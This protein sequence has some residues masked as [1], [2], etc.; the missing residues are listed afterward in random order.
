VPLVD[1]PAILRKAY[2]FRYDHAIFGKE[3]FRDHVHTNIEGYRLLGLA[4]FDELVSE[5]IARPDAA[6]GVAREAAVRQEV[7]ADLDPAVEGMA[8]LNLGKVLDWAGK[9]EEAYDAY[10]WA[11]TILGPSPLLYD[12]LSTCSFILKKYDDTIHY[13]NQTLALYPGTRGIHYKLA[14]ALGMQGKTDEAIEQCRQ[15]L[16]I[17]PANEN[18]HYALANLYVVKGDEAAALEEFRMALQLKPDDVYAHVKLA[19]LLI[20]QERY[21]EALPH[22]QEALQLEPEQYRMHVA[23]GHAL[24]K[25]GKSR[26]AMVHFSEALR[27]QP[28]DDFAKSNLQELHAGHGKTGLDDTL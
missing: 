1:F 26:E 28:D 15:E 24:K 22:L 25:L 8:M 21:D 12:S 27:L 20:R 18:A 11:L 16:E 2:L 10:Q 19:D 5:G 4:L 17:N 6:W 9:F 23:L 7:M 14:M 3:Y 13:L